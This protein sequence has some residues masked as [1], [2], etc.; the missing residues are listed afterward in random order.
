MDLGETGRLAIWKIDEPADFFTGSFVLSQDEETE[1]GR[2]KADLK[3][4]QWLAARYLLCLLTP[5]E[6]RDPIQKDEHGKPHF[7]RSGRYLSISHSGN[8]AAVLLHP[9]ACGIDIQLPTKKLPPIL[10]RVLNQKE[11]DR[12]TSDPSLHLATLM[13]AAK[14]SLYKAYG[15]KKLDFREHILLQSIDFRQPEFQAWAT[16]QKERVL[17]EYALKGWAEDAFGV[18]WAFQK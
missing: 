7:T 9:R 8:Y 2:I 4:K 3:R 6:P 5:D 11:M 10:P 1:L 14:E 13:W 17:L 15:H 18:V 16:V 12:I